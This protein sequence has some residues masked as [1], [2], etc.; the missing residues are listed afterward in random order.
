MWYALI[1]KLAMFSFCR[2]VQQ[3]PSVG[4][5]SVISGISDAPATMVD[6][7]LYGC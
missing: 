5:S 4:T 1:M 7:D 2:L 6:N 3:E